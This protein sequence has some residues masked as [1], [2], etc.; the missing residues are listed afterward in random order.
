M[1]ITG[2]IVLLNVVFGLLFRPIPITSIDS[3]S[4]LETQPDL[5]NDNDAAHFSRPSKQHSFCSDGFPPEI[6][7]NGSPLKPFALQMGAG[8]ENGKYSQVA[9]M[10][11]SHPVLPIQ[12][13]MPKPEEQYGSHSRIYEKSDNRR[14]LSRR[15]SGVMLRKDILYAGSLYNIPEYK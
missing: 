10:A 11:L 12:P 9:R 7:I 4:T 2:A 14:R 6:R 15:S 1:L 8:Q 3:G 5:E 13:P